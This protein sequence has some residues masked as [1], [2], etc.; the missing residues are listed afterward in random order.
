[1]VNRFVSAQYHYGFLCVE[2][3]LSSTGTGGESRFIHD[4]SIRSVDAIQRSPGIGTY[5]SAT[6]VFV[7]LAMVRE[8]GRLHR[9]DSQ[10]R[11]G[12]CLKS[13]LSVWVFASPG[14]KS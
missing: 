1:M 7:C 2:Y 6:T 5:V 11:R 12:E 13:T 14:I 3:G 9:A 10:G 4:S 8:G